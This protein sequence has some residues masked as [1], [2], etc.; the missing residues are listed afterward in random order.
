[1]EGQLERGMVGGREDRHMKDTACWETPA[2]NYVDEV[3]TRDGF[4]F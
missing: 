4:D 1:M 2:G 3:E